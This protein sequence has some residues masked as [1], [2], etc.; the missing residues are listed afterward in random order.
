VHRPGASFA[1]HDRAILRSLASQV[2]ITLENTRLYQHLDGLFR[3][4]LSPDIA[5]ALIADPEQAALGGGLAEVTVLMADLTGFTPFSERSQP[6]DV[7]SM[8]NTYYGAIVP[9]ILDSGGTVTQF[10]GD[11]VMALFNAPVRQPD[12]A[13]R[14]ARAGLRIQ[15]AAAAV[16]RDGW[17]RFAGGSARRDPAAAGGPGPRQGQGRAGGGVPSR[18]YRRCRAMTLS[19]HDPPSAVGSGYAT[20]RC[21]VIVVGR[22]PSSFCRSA[23]SA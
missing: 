10:I 1:P 19:G 23:R 5:R 15:R 13:L 2:S 4:Y 12:H 20:R 22:R 6:A 11:A 14:A 21:A 8:L 17:P 9:E 3:A 16:A 7:V 18:G